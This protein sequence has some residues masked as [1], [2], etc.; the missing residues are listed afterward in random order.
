MITYNVTTTKQRQHMR[1]IYGAWRFF[2]FKSSVPGGVAVIFENIILKLNKK[3]STCS[4]D[5]RS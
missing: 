1:I 4:L 2:C 3:D 5:A